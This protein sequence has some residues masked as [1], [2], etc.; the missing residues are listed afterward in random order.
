MVWA[1]GGVD[2]K[3][4]SRSS[5]SGIVGSRYVNREGNDVV[6]VYVV[7]PPEIDGDVDNQLSFMSK[8]DVNVEESTQGNHWL[9]RGK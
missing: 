4:S 9:V 8:G 2:G 3:K 7:H 5:S 6:D 1:S